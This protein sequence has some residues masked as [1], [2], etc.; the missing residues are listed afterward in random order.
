MQKVTRRF[1]RVFGAE[2]SVHLARSYRPAY[3]LSFLLLL[4][5]HSAL[6]Q[7]NAEWSAY[8]SKCGIAA[9]IAYSDW[10]AQG[11][12][13]PNSNSGGSG[14]AS[15]APALTPQQQLGLALGQAAMPYLQQAVHNLFYGSPKTQPILAPPDPA[16]EQRELA[17]QQLNNSGLYL[18]KQKNYAGAI[19]EFQKAL[20]IIPNDSNTLHNLAL[21]K[22]QQKDAAV[23][24]QTSGA[25]GQFLGNAPANTGIFSFAQLTSSTVA[26]PNASALSLVNLDSDAN[27]VDLRGTT[28]TSV[29]RESL[30]GQLDR[31]LANNAPASAP[32]GSQVVPPQD[33]D[34]ELLSTLSQP[35]PS[36]SQ[37][38]L[39]QDKDEELLST[40][41]QPGPSQSQVVQPQDK[42]MELLGFPPPS[43]GSNLNNGKASTPATAGNGGNNSRL[44]PVPASTLNQIG[45][46]SDPSLKD[47]VGDRPAQASTGGTTNAFGTTSNPSN[48]DL[49]SSV[50][51]PP[52][53]VHSAFD[54]L[55]SAANSG[56]AA[57]TNARS[58]GAKV[59]SN[60]ALDT[61]ACATYVPVAVNKVVAQTPGASADIQIPAY[62]TNNPQVLAQMRI[63]NLYKQQAQDARTAAAAAQ[64]KFEAAQ[65]Q[66]VPS[67]Q[68]SVLQGKARQAESNAKSLDDMVTV[69]TGEVR[70]TIKFAKFNT[71]GNGNSTPQDQVPPLAPTN[72]T[73]N[74]NH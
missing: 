67:D 58:D 25:L 33:K 71:G 23:A 70:N 61:S 55:S 19:N 46:A 11:S 18:L 22:Q 74:Q 48:P 60:C 47:A 65:K 6:A 21:A 56:T 54:Q 57:I 72:P 35:G 30:K 2:R 1:D 37:V 45:P 38:V 16:E 68:L 7:S 73:A 50:P 15:S 69:Q 20:A 24:G 17:A 36:Q 44:N 4:V 8:K 63:L 43:G 12:P 13:C 31:V 29:D 62:L 10:Q 66:G 27:V 53:A 9:G 34:M 42:D 26:N 41:S 51:T 39:P 52:V 49:N 59:E 40:L 28:K 3:L 14:T 32:P 5:P 64:A